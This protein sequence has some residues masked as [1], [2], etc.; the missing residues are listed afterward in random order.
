MSTL[1]PLILDQRVP[2]K[3]LVILLIFKTTL[4]TT[5]EVFRNKAKGLAETNRKTREKG[6]KARNKMK[7]GK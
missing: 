1:W 7:D 3:K 2:Y 4:I 5:M 6:Q